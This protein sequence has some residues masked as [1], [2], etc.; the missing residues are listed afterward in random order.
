MENNEAAR[1]N[2]LNGR[3][4]DLARKW[5]FRPIEEM[6]GGH[7]SSVFAN[8]TCVLKAPFR[9]E[10]LTSGFHAALALSGNA[11]PRVM[12][13]DEATGAVLMERAIP[14]YSLLGAKLSEE[15]SMQIAWDLAKQ[16]NEFAPRRAMPI[17]VY[18]DPDP[19]LPD[20]LRTTPRRVFLHGD[21]HH[22]N[23]LRHG[24]RWMAI[25]P[26]GIVG[27]PAY[28]PAAFMRNPISEIPL[29]A[30]PEGLFRNRIRWFAKA[31]E[32]DPKRICGWSLTDM[33]SFKSIAWKNA[34][35]AIERIF[36]EL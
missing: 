17:E 1:R 32:M 14:G 34:V 6:P 20:L 27:D 21:L 2:F 24:E 8:E 31:G 33:R 35:A 29:I 18:C 36:A 5:N 16:I 11:G 13:A 25:D 22:E 3:I 4:R 12:D 10:E 30:N 23:S 28:E 15:D 9:G 26:K 7:C 19:L